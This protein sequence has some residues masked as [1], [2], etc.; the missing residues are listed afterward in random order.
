MK[1]SSKN[2]FSDIST[3]IEIN[4]VLRSK[5][6]KIVLF[7]LFFYV[8]NFKKKI[9]KKLGIRIK[10]MSKIVISIDISTFKEKN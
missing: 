8:K 1:I 2:H 7:F 10:K 6:K 5:R 9:F 4:E 3:F